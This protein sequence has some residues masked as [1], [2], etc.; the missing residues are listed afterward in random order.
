MRPLIAASVV[1]LAVP[2]T[3]GV[4]AAI[5]APTTV[6]TTPNPTTSE[7]R[8]DDLDAAFYVTLASAAV[9]SAEGKVDAD[10]VETLIDHL[11]YPAALSTSDVSASIDELRVETAAL[12]GKREAF[13]SAA[14]AAAAA[15]QE[16]AEKAA[17]EQAAAALAAT[18]TPDGAR[19]TARTMAASDYGWGDD[20]FSCLDSL[21]QKE[22]SW[23]YQAYNPSGATGIPQALPGSKMASAGSDWQTNA[24]TQIAW[25][26]GYIADVY[27]TP[28]AA[29]GHSQSVNWY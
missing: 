24:A 12:V 20:Q 8:A 4:A 19:S 18:N 26:L 5:S 28:C 1:A 23:N 29:W 21:W 11:Q 10:E 14:A 3:T 15:A 13:D 22:S 27:G 16:A 7:P 17:A 6:L 9:S 2:L 25:G